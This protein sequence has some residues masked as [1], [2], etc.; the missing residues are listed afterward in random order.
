MQNV[1]SLF[2]AVTGMFE[3]IMAVP[4]AWFFWR[5]LLWQKLI[6]FISMTVIFLSARARGGERSRRARAA[7]L[8]LARKRG[9]GGLTTAALATPVLALC[10]ARSPVHRR[11]RHVRAARDGTAASRARRALRAAACLCAA[12]AHPPALRCAPAP[13]AR[14]ALAPS[15][16]Y[17]D[18][19]KSSI[20][21]PPHISGSLETR[22]SYTYKVA[23]SAMFT[24]TCTTV[25][26]LGITATARIPFISTFGIFA[27]L[28]VL[29]DYILVIT[30]F[31]ITVVVYATYIEKSKICGCLPCCRPDESVPGEEQP[32]RPSVVFL[33]EKV[34][35]VVYKWRKL[36]FA[37]AFLLFMIFLA[38][39]ATRYQVADDFPPDT[40]DGHPLTETSDIIDTKFFQSEDW[41]YAVWV[42][43]GFVP[44][45]P[46]TYVES[47]Q[48]VH[49][50]DV[51]REYTVNYD[52][53]FKLDKNLQEAIVEDCE[54][55]RKD[56]WMVENKQVYCLLNLLRS[57]KPEDWPYE[58]ESDL[59]K[60][61][62]KYLDSPEYEA[63]LGDFADYGRKSGFVP[64]GDDGIKSYWHSFNSTIPQ[65][66][67]PGPESVQ[68]HFDKWEAYTQ[69]NCAA[70]CFH[71]LPGGQGGDI[72]WALYILLS[73]LVQ[74]VWSSIMYSLAAAFFV[75]NVTTLNWYISTMVVS[76]IIV[77]IICVLSTIFAIGNTLGVF[78]SVFAVLCIGLAI[79]YAVHIAHFYNHSPG[80]RFEKTQE[81]V[82][83]IAISV[84]GGAATTVRARARAA[85][86]RAPPDHASRA[87]ARLRPL[88]SGAAPQVFA[89]VPLFLATGRFNY[90]F[91]FFILF[92]S[93]WA[94]TMTFIMLVPWLMMVGPEGDFG[95]FEWVLRWF[96]KDYRNSV[97]DRRSNGSAQ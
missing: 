52:P 64:D 78:E 94:V 23:A 17:M 33:R 65:E 76:V 30:W 20:S 62:D 35:P 46:V 40:V 39:F 41:K 6:D 26:C 25:L 81:S 24:T 60:A 93:G 28:V 2:L 71:F 90:T 72:S 16:V 55:L 96:R 80:T 38:V 83:K 92:T 85:A 5:I 77:I 12:R 14:P 70:P 84:I 67:K 79:D 63:V 1:G 22:L 32:E 68:P 15:F 75:L 69:A 87:R 48:M 34:T 50:I 19:W 4:L 29:C 18:T 58:K 66:T 13:A 45:E 27:A 53:D 37:L 31:P 73:T 91:G 54:Q 10:A 42:V 47:G 36:I 21:K 43:Y 56:K 82:S 95:S 57:W 44:N 11:R 61:L 86:S 9:P 89:G 7:A 51:A 97:R 8:A 3:I 74:E 88:P 49:R 59:R